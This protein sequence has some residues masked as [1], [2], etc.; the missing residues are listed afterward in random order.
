MVHLHAFLHQF[1]YLG[2]FAIIFFESGVPVTFFLPGDSLLF[3]TGYLS[4]IGILNV[5]VSIILIAIASILG[6]F[7]G[8][9]IG[10]K[11]KTS[12]LLKKMWWIKQDHIDKTHVF[13]E[14]YGVRA[15]L[16]SRFIPAVRS[17][18]SFV[19]GLGSMN[20]RLFAVYNVL[21]GLVWASGMTL[22]GFYTGKKFPSIEHYLTYI[23]VA[24]VLV[25][26]IPVFTEYRK[27][28]QMK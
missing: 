5:W 20:Y 21:G 2:L 24:V 1:G 22:I 4:S 25:S 15:L 26:F 19:A 7:L 13:I 23:V 14:E 28:K 8:F 17:V 9:F 12:Q 18:A 11:F 3:V 6:Y 16:F 27:K 10:D